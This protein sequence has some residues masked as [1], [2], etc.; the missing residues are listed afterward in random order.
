MKLSK[1]STGGDNKVLG[2]EPLW[3]EDRKYTDIDMIIAFNWY[4]YFCNRK[5][6]KTFVIEYLGLINRPKEEISLIVACPDAVFPVQFGWLARMM[7]LG[8][9]PSDKTKKFFTKNYEE[10]LKKSKVIKP[11]AKD[12]PPTAQVV[13]VSIQDRIREK[14]SEEIGE[15]EGYID[16]FILNS[17]KQKN[18]IANFLKSRQYSSVVCKRVCDTFI[19]RAKDIGEVLLGEDDQLK[20]GYSNFTK[21]E[22]KR[23]KE[24]LDTIVSETNRMV[25]DNKPVRKQRKVKE[26]PANVIV[27]KMKYLKEFAELNLKSVAPERVV[28]ASQLWTYNTK[29]K[30]L[31]VYNADN[32]KGLTVKGSTLQ[33][34]NEQTSIGKRL[35]KPD[36]VLKDLLDAG[37]VKLK[38]ILPDLTT[39]ESTLTGRMNDDII[40]VR[41]V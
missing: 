35:R 25:T 19:K 26:K 23:F 29:T 24:L 32:A 13:V 28:C 21:P 9:T 14:A 22:L 36:V 2:Q 3:G 1:I 33:N 37:K 41:I 31:G 11:V 20:E 34:F 40:I 5:N 8:Y 6:A 27:A 16:E 39:K 30:L 4:N 10:L 12:E 15:I 18:D 7:S 17:C 38:R